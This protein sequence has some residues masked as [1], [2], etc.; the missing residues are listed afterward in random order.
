MKKTVVIYKSTS[1]FTKKYA[2]WIA[3]SLNCD[4]LNRKQ[5]NLKKILDYEIIIYGGSLHAVGISGVDII[6]KNLPSLKEK[7]I[8]IFATGASP[9]RPEIPS[10]VLNRNFTSDQQKQITFFYL[11]GGFDFNKLDLVNKALMTLM[12]WKIKSKKE[13]D[14]DDKGMMAAFSN[15]IDFTDKDNLKELLEFVRSKQ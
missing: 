7:T 12:K 9:A 8:V 10:V 4:L 6:S 1:G 5:A 11:R 3:Q 2:E 15:P 14:S 13:W